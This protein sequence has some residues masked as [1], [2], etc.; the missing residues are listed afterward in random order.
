[1][2]RAVEIFSRSLGEEHP[3]AQ[4]ARKNL[5]ALLAE[6]GSTEASPPP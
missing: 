3:T 2:W 5:E 4:T 1:M 6:M